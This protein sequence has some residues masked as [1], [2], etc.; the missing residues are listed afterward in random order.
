M[1][2]EIQ[3][4]NV[5]HTQR[6]NHIPKDPS[7]NPKDSSRSTKGP[8]HS[9]KGPSHIP[10]VQFTAHTVSPWD[11]TWALGTVTWALRAVTGPLGCDLGPMGC[12]LGSLG[13]NLGHVGSA[14]AE[15]EGGGGGA[16]S[17]TLQRPCVGQTRPPRAHR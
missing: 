12:D 8:N 4:Y 15:W 2:R 6:A 7:L 14:T 3:Y 1:A 11:V 16:P 9:T 17:A 13:C 5:E 10:W